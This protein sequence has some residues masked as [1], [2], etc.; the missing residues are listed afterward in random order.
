MNVSRQ[1]RKYLM[2]MDYYDEGDPDLMIEPIDDTKHRKTWAVC[3]EAYLRRQL[4]MLYNTPELQY[5]HEGNIILRDVSLPLPVFDA[6]SNDP[7]NIRMNQIM[8]KSFM[9]NG[10]GHTTE[11]IPP[12]YKYLTWYTLNEPENQPPKYRCRPAL[13]NSMDCMALLHDNMEH[14]E[15]LMIKVAY[16][17]RPFRS[18]LPLTFLFDI[19]GGFESVPAIEFY[20]PDH[21]TKYH[22]PDDKA[23]ADQFERTFFEQIMQKRP[24]S[25]EEVFWPRRANAFLAGGSLSYM[26]S[27]TTEFRDLDLFIEFDLETFAFISFMRITTGTIDHPRNRSPVRIWI[28]KELYYDEVDGAN[29][30]HKVQ[31]NRN[32]FLHAIPN[33]K[34]IFQNRN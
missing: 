18:V 15:D 6:N 5:E 11:C 21:T 27:L 20:F 34:I 8:I 3:F 24:L 29:R 10:V 17:L 14:P 16:Y 2:Q 12:D 19:F 33:P 31:T 9:L 7:D 32:S 22:F 4:I 28:R 26:L 30:K 1:Y 13:L 25:E 23:L